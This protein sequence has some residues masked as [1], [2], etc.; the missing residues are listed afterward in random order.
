M[1]INARVGLSSINPYLTT[2]LFVGLG[3]LSLKTFKLEIKWWDLLVVLSIGV[4]VYW[5][6]TIYPET[7]FAVLEFGPS[8]VLGALPYY[9]VGASVSLERHYDLFISIGRI[10]VLVNLL[11]STISLL[12]FTNTFNAG[13]ES[14]G[15][16]YNMLPSVILVSRNYLYRHNQQDFLLTIIGL[17]VLMSLGTRG[18]IVAFALFIVL[19]YLFCKNY[20]SSISSRIAILLGFGIFY[21]LLNPILLILLTIAKSFGFGTRAYD[22]ILEGDVF[23]AENREWIYDKV[24]DYIIYDKS[25]IGY[26]FF[27]DRVILGM[28]VS[29][30]CHN[31]FYEVC[32]D[33]GIYIGGALLILFFGAVIVNM[34]KYRKSEASSLYLALFCS[35]VVQLFFSLSYLKSVL[36]WFFVGVTISSLRNKIPSHTNTSNYDKI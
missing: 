5:S 14:M 22:A 26:G 23:N 28:D 12:G 13:E 3:V 35:C 9:V 36:F 2:T 29:S 7:T 18:P 27:Y 17:F 15:L 19:F 34:F 16:A 1:G 25:N 24:V 33:F 8:F 6:P 32:L 30:Y 10:G 20:T 4:F 21:L 11:I 31:L